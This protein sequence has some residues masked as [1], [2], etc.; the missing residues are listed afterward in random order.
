MHLRIIWVV[1][2]K[3]RATVSLYLG[4]FVEDI[5]HELSEKSSPANCHCPLAETA[6]H[7]KCLLCLW[8]S[9]ATP[10]LCCFSSQTRKISARA[11]FSTDQEK[12]EYQ[13]PWDFKTL[14]TAFPVVHP[15]TESGFTVLCTGMRRALLPSIPCLLTHYTYSCRK[16]NPSYHFFFP[17]HSMQ[18]IHILVITGC[19][20]TVPFEA[21]G[22]HCT[23][24]FAWIFYSGLFP[25]PSLPLVSFFL[26][27]FFFR[28]VFRGLLWWL[29]W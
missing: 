16:L 26:V 24:T 9:W 8:V 12:A 1:C 25:W 19:L 18:Q 23:D 20:Y 17:I 21:L 29:R 28:V 6:E 15:A 27:C 10:G 11:L 3:Y 13:H 7:L 4:E 14:L 2:W 22:K 5:L